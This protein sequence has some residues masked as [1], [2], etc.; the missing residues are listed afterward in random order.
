MLQRFIGVEPRHL[1]ALAAVAA[2]GSF[3]AAA[4][5][6]GYVQSAVRQQIAQLE[7]TIGAPLIDRV[8]G[9]STVA[10][11][12]A[13]ATLVPH[14]EAIIA[15]LDA[16]AADL[17]ALERSQVELRIGISDRG[18]RPLLLGTLARLSRIAPHVVAQVCEAGDAHEQGLAVRHGALDAAFADLPLDPGPFAAREVLAD[19]VVLVVRADTPLAASTEPL[20]LGDLAEVPLIVDRS[21]R[22]VRLMEARMRAFGLEPRLALQVDLSASVQAL[23]AAGIGAALLPRMAL[24]ENDPRVVALDLDDVIPPRRLALYWHADRRRIGGLQALVD[25]ALSATGRVA[26]PPRFV[27]RTAGVP[28]AA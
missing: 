24:D 25:A 2:E 4:D 17:R 15:Q 21:W 9:M 6:R 7:R 13:G 20:T 1:A 16:A 28:A 11:T 10:L 12:D 22:A 5:R 27:R 23:V 14:A 18:A 8:R 19:P 26:S 3:K